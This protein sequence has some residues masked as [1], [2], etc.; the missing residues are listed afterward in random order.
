MKEEW[1]I[2]P[3]SFDFDHLANVRPQ[4]KFHERSKNI[5]DKSLNENIGMRIRC[6]NYSYAK[7]IDEFNLIMGLSGTVLSLN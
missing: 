1:Q 2:V 5:S 3:E 6:G 4:H 7:I